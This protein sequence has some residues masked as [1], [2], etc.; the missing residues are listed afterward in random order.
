MKTV[1]LVSAIAEWRAVKEIFPQLEIE[2]SAYGESATL[3]VV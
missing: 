3:N 1:V 2:N